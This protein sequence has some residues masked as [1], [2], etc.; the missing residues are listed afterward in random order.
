[1]NAADDLIETS[2]FWVRDA[3]YWV[4]DQLVDR[5]GLLPLGMVIVI[6]IT[7]CLIGWRRDRL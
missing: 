3:L 6:L 1:M 7:L 5:P 2:A 4:A